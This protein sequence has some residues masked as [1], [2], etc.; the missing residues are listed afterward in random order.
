MSVGGQTWIVLVAVLSVFVSSCHTLGG[1]MFLLLSDT[2]SASL[3]V[4][5]LTVPYAARRHHQ[6]A[7]WPGAGAR[8]GCE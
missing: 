4:L 2:F 5:Q 1:C 7:V 3:L 8:G 6:I